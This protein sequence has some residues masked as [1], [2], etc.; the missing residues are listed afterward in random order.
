MGEITFTT[1]LADIG[2][3][4]LTGF[5]VGWPNPP[6]PE[7]HLRLL[8]AS[9][10]VVLARDDQRVIGYITALT[11]HVLFSS[12]T[13]IEVL[14]G[15]QG[16]GIGRELMRR[17][18]DRLEVYATDVV[19]DESISPFYERLGMRRVTGMV[20]RRYDLQSGRLG[21]S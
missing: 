17:I 20:H 13:S 8:Y 1:D 21:P 15:Y 5:F 2:P 19:C 11:D 3:E 4:H 7:I 16:R 9:D 6:S 12:I 10:A 14:P 18:V